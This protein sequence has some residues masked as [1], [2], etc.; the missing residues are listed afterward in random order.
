VQ[1]AAETGQVALH[2]WILQP[3]AAHGLHAATV[4]PVN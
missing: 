1:Q 3:W 2:R 4:A